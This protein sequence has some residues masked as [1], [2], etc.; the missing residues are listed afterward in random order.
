MQLLYLLLYIYEIH[1]MHPHTHPY[2]YIRYVLNPITRVRFMLC[3]Y[4]NL[5]VPNQIKI[6]FIRKSK[7][8]G[9]QTC[10]MLCGKQECSVYF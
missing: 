8:G 6:F 10:Q 4:A 2:I 3:F 1:C 9:K 7:I 5:R